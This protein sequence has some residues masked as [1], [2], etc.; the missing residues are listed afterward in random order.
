MSSGEEQNEQIKG[1]HAPAE[2][3][4][5]GVRIARKARV[6]SESEKNQEKAVQE[7]QDN[8]AADDA[9]VVESRNILA[10][11]GLAAQTNKDYPK[12]AVRA[13]H[14]KPIP[15]HQ[16]PTHKPTPI[17]FQPSKQ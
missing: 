5:G 8:A 6:T 1:G 13:Y 2:K 16:K 4:A 9:A 11:T 12:E 14:E 3:I 15:Q 17:V 7:T 10:H